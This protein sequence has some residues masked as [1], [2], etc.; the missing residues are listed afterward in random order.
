MN[1]PPSKHSNKHLQLSEKSFTKDYEEALVILANTT[2]DWEKR[3]KMISKLSDYVTTIE[4]TPYVIKSFD[5]LS[6]CI[7]AQ[8]GDLRSSIIRQIAQ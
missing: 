3:Q 8:F 1:K 2:T 5:K 6:P 7:M 4:L